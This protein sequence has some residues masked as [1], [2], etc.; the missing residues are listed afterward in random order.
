MLNHV[1]RCIMG[2]RE[3]GSVYIKL[4]GAQGSSGFVQAFGLFELLNYQD[5]YFAGADGNEVIQG[6]IRRIC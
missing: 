5:L 1:N 4:H 3:R 6:I 2:R